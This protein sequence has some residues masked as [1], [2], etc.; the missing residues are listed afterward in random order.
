MEFIKDADGKIRME[1]FYCGL[2]DKENVEDLLKN[3]HPMASEVCEPVVEGFVDL[4][5]RG[6]WSAD[7][8][9][10]AVDKEGRVH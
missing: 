10:I 9:I 3:K 5:E 4:I 6:K 8:G 2:I 7:T 1:G